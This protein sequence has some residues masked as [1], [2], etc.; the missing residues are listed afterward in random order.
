VPEVPNEISVLADRLCFCLNCS[1]STKW[2][3]NSH[4]FEVQQ[5]QQNR[6]AAIYIALFRVLAD[7][8]AASMGSIFSSDLWIEKSSSR[9]RSS[10]SASS[11]IVLGGIAS[12]IAR[13]GY[14]WCTKNA[15]RYGTFI[16]ALLAK[17]PAVLGLRPRGRGQIA[18][19]R[20]GCLFTLAGL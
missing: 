16:C 7:C 1:L 3:E 11:A 15:V 17:I 13:K 4:Y 9:I 2:C 14:S 10:R 20:Y 19:A 12:F 5:S 6:D 8:A 18:L